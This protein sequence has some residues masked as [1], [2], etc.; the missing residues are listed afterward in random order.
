MVLGETAAKAGLLLEP[1][2][3]INS[4]GPILE[5]VVSSNLATVLPE[6]TAS[7]AKKYLPLQVRRI[8]DPP[9]KRQLWVVRPNERPLTPIL[10]RLIDII[11]ME[12][13]W[14]QLSWPVGVNYL[15]R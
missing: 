11:R 3:E 1:R 7:R 8:I 4:P 2:L 12:L 15:G 13:G 10:N 9:L 14:R 5:M 6:I